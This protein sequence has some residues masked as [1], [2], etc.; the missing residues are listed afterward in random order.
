[1]K[2]EKKKYSQWKFITFFVVLMGVFAGVKYVFGIEVPMQA[3]PKVE[4]LMAL[5]EQVKEVV[6]E[7]KDVEE[8]EFVLDDIENPEEE[9]LDEEEEKDTVVLPVPVVKGAHR[10]KGV[11]S[12]AQCFPD[13]QSVQI[14]AAQKYGIMPVQNRMEAEVLVK[15]RKLV[16]ICH[17]P[18]YAI[19]D[20]THSI[21]YLVPRA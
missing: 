3:K 19:D 16:N 12:Y 1:M 11:W 13:S 10:V 7:E 2:K 14:E 8:E 21:P 9:V 4:K 20:L 17:S 6:P 5:A 15:Q 18:F